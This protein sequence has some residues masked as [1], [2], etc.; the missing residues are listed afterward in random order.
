M[1]SKR[2]IGELVTERP[3]RSRVFA[4]HG[5]D[6]CCGGGKS[7]GAACASKG[8]EV[9]VL[10]AELEA[11]EAPA[12]GEP[13]FAGM[14]LTELTEHLVATHHAY[15]RSELPRLREMVHKVA[16]VHAE[17][18]ARLPMLVPVFDALYMDLLPHLDKEEM[19]LFPAIR[20]MEAGREAGHCFGHVSAP[21]SVMESE[22]EQVGRLLAR[23]RE[24]CSDYVVPP[25]ACNT[26]RAMLDGLEELEADTHQHVHLENNL[27]H[28]RVLAMADR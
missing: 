16:R 15:L 9:E 3:S 1:D 7:L 20:D 5:I 21:I 4:R 25:E 28:A 26:W 18:D 11:A 27:L 24:L 19:I 8:L 12:P 6:Y 14:S 13:D 23:M 17:K 22:H 2:T 10:I